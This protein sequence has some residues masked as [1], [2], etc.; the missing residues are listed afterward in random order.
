V[1]VDSLTINTAGIYKLRV[2]ND[3]CSAES[4]T[5]F[6]VQPKPEF[7]LR[8]DT[9]VC[10]N[11]QILQFF[12]SNPTAGTG[13]WTGPGITE[14]GTWNPGLVEAGLIDITYAL[15]SEFGCIT[16]KSFKIEVGALPDVQVSSSLDTVE[17]NAPVTISASGG[18]AFEWSPSAGLNITNGP[19]VIA[20]LPETRIYKV[21]V[22]SDKGCVAEKSIEIIVDQEFKIYDA[23][24]P[25]GDFKNDVWYIKNILRYPSAKVY[26]FNRW[27]N[28]VFESEPGYPN[29]WNGTFKD[30]PVPPG[31][32]FYTIDLGQGLTPKSGSIT[33]IR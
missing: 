5:N 32:Y 31:A 17:V 2:E 3:I 7:G 30:D 11:T 21:K 33:V 19:S 9:S 14:S 1:N 22:T 12:P 10:K 25:N 28:Q 15:K 29:P 8:G 24:S 23:F 27:G 20:K 4:S 16:S 6:A 13:V 26:I 18:V